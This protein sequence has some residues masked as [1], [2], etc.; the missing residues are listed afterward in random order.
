MNLQRTAAVWLMIALCA[1]R[2]LAQEE[3]DASV[4]LIEPAPALP[5]DAPLSAAVVHVPASAEPSELNEAEAEAL[6][7]EH[8]VTE[9]SERGALKVYG[10]TDFGLDKWFLSSRNGV[11]LIRP[12]G[13]TTFVF[14]NL[15]LYFDV[16]PMER[17]RTLI[18]LRFTLAPHG[19]EIQFGPPLGDSYQRID[20]T[21]FDFT[22]PTSQAQLRLSGLF[23]ERAVTEYTFSE[24][25]T[26]RWG[27]YLNPFGIWN[28]DHGS[29]TLI[30]LTL[31]TFIAAQM[32]P[33]RLLGVHAYGSY[34][35]GGSELAYS[36]HV[37]NGR[38]PLD[39]DLTEDKAVGARL[40]YAHDWQSA[41]LVLGT[42]G[43]F[44]TYVD[45]EKAINLSAA[46]QSASFAADDLYRE[47]RTIDFTEQVVGF[48]VALDIG[49]LRLRSEAVLRWVE[50]NGDKSERISTPD[51]SIQYLPNRLEWSGYA[52]AAYRT[53]FR[54]EP[55]VEVELAK[56]SY[57]LPRWAGPSRATASNY[58]SIFLSV[59]LNL[60]VTAYILIKSQFVWAHAYE[61][62]ITG[63][64]ADVATLFLRIVDSF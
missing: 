49:A 31:P 37:S 14:G 24:L 1:T 48:D 40:H 35:S 60:Q 53:P 13:A 10:F 3:M 4:P 21:T 9:V 18:E 43:Y 28:L 8:D 26:L 46:A 36:L 47:N 50:Y 2:V 19:E 22:N 58:S 27:L 56:K 59:G 23:I 39:V 45:T 12:T 30:G 44:G 11:G 16:A 41:R 33:A 34:I 17:V 55:Y 62:D 51:G 5:G 6:L 54:L 25:F 38:S 63:P 52:L 57:T 64:G 29:P 61:G 32:I 15:N 20:T 42:S 7:S